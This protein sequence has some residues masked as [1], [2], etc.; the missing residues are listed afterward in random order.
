MSLTAYIRYDNNNRIVPGGPIVV[1]EKPNTGNWQV[2]TEGNNVT[3]SG[4]LRAFVK[5]DRFG[6]PIAGS[7]F[8]GYKRPTTGQWIEVNATYEGPVSPTTTTTTSTST[9][10]STTTT[11]TTIAVYTIGQQALGGVIAYILQPGDPGYDANVQHGL[12]ATVN[13][14]S[15]GLAAGWGCSGQFISNASN[16]AIGAGSVNTDSIVNQCADNGAARI[17]FDLVQGGYSDWVLP[18]SN[19][20]V[21]LWNN[22]FSIGGF[23]NQY[24]WSSTQGDS[25]AGEADNAYVLF[26]NSG[27]IYNVQKFADNMSVR[28]IRYF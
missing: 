11:T 9:S 1:K 19:E 23:G 8:L 14:I 10:T 16:T 2:V 20:L 7:L 15:N 25:G 28:A 26:N 13:D 3:L 5:V 4:K 27:I 22:R 18:S 6:K 17:C 12:V 21:A 24:Y